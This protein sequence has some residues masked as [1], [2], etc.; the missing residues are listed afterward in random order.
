MVSPATTP[1]VSG[2]NSGMETTNAVRPTN[3]P[4]WVTRS[5]NG[6]P[7][8][9]SGVSDES[10]TATA[11]STGTAARESNIAQVRR[12]RNKTASSEANSAQPTTTLARGRFAAVTCFSLDNVEPLPRQRDET[13]LEAR[14]VHGEG[15][16]PHIAGNQRGN[17]HFGR[18]ALLG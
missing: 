6:G 14:P 5:R 13:V 8:P 16:H 1:T 17:D 3:S 18:R 11:M 15:P 10:R 12:R 2:R 9:G 7:R 4:F